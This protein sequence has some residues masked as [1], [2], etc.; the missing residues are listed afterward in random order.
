MR[1]SIRNQLAG[2][3][4]SVTRGEVMG[5]IGVRLSGGQD[6]TAAITLDAIDDLKLTDGLDA[7]V[8]L[9]STEVSVA[10]GQV[11]QLSIRNQIPATIFEVEPGAVMTV[12]RAT[13][14]GGDTITAAITKDGADDL[15]LAPG[16]PVTMLIKST[17]VGIGVA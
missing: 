10:I 5:T 9:K 4:E 15:E 17:D 3:I 2:V 8:L 14:A 12:I 6:I 7:T 13:I 1:L 16:D 11:P